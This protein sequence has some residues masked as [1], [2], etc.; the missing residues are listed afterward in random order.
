MAKKSGESCLGI[1]IKMTFL[2]TLMAILGISGIYFTYN[3]LNEFFNRGGTIVV[4][5]FRGRHLEEILRNK[6]D[7]LEIIRRDER[8]DAN[9]PKDHV[10]AQFPEPNTVVKPGKQIMLSVSLGFQRVIVPDLIGNAIRE[11]DVALLNA[12][13]S[14]GNKAYVFSNHIAPDRVVGQSPMPSEEYGINRSVDLLIS[15]GTKPELVPL[16]NLSSMSLEAAK[17]SLKSWGFNL[18][19]VYSTQDKKRARFRIISTNPAPYSYMRKGDTVNILI[20]SGYDVGS[21]SDEELRAFRVLSEEVGAAAKFDMSGFK[22]LMPSANTAVSGAT[23]QAVGQ[24]VSAGP[25]NVLV[26]EAV[27]GVKEGAGAAGSIVSTQR[28]AVSTQGIIEARAMPEPVIDQGA[29]GTEKVAGAEQ[30]A[31]VTSLNIA[32]PK[33]EIS[34]MM[35]DGFMPKELKLVHISPTKREEIYV[36]VHKPLEVVKVNTPIMPNSKVQVYINDIPIEELKI[37]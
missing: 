29:G 7:G 22:A 2:L 28:A 30:A 12:Q 32:A 10:I 18:G 13:L 15:L 4:P 34:Y 33:K 36:G 21:A 3:K 1:L 26:P 35:P 5:D 25:G 6:P 20:S 27:G 31:T 9:L 24:G 23:S 8:Y 11:V 37:D 19:K 14:A 17:A 16:P